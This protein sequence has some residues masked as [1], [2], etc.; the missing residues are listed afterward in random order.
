MQDFTKL[1]AW[2]RAHQLALDVVRALP[3]RK[4]RMVPG[5]RPQ[6][7]RVALSVP[8]NL[9]EGCGKRSSADL[10]HYADIA[11]GS[12][13]ELRAHLLMARDTGILDPSTHRELAR[14]LEGVRCL[15]IALARAVRRQSSVADA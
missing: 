14:S 1:T 4:C 8:A 6:A 9:A 15:L 3:A 11:C 5:L 2:A 10:A 13:L 7:I 12:L